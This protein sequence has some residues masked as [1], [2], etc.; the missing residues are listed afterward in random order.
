M[1]S[2][3]NSLKVAWHLDRSGLLPI[4]L[5]LVISDLCNQN[6]SF[7]SYRMEGGFSSQ[8]FGED[9]GK[10][11]TMNPNRKIPKEKCFEILDD[12]KRIGI[13]A[14]QFTG[15]GEPTVHPSH[16]EIFKH[17]QEIGL[18]TALVSNGTSLPEFDVLRNFDW[19]RISLDAG[20]EETYQR[21]RDSNLWHRVMSNLHRLASIEGPYIGVGF[22]VTKDNWGE[23]PYA[24]KLVKDLGIPYMRVSAV[25]SPEEDSYYNSFRSNVAKQITLAKMY[26]D[27]EFKIVDLFEK[28]LE[29]LNLGQ[30]KNSL[31]GYQRLTI[32]IGGDQNIYRC[33]TTSYTDQGLI[34]SLKDQR[35]IDWWETEADGMYDNF[36]AKTCHHCQ[37]NAQNET[38][39]YITEDSPMHVDFV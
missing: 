22:V 26:E 36:D 14:V 16:N 39:A 32:Y 15:G 23:L 5:Q 12:C 38:I 24:A 9:T 10:G 28:R 27:D 34:G 17:A 18:Q 29:D 4:H 1:D 19:I 21:I 8:N 30:P 6:C 7:C 33:C 31:C 25:F 35:F 13:R 2:P 20:K 3:Y 37:F 11:F